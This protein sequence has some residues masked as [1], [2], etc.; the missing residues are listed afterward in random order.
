MVWAALYGLLLA[1]YVGIVGSLLRR[2]G[3]SWL[4]AWVTLVPFGNLVLLFVVVTKDWPIERKL[5]RLRLIAGESEDVDAD[6]ETIISYAITCEH[7][8]RWDQ[9]VTL[10][11][12]AADKSPD[13]RVKQY[14]TECA[15]RL[16]SNG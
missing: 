7:K 15:Q 13:P 4:W 1:V 14:A 6:I 12:F 8:R 2:I 3:Y 5:A 16:E 11:N 9:A 10:Y